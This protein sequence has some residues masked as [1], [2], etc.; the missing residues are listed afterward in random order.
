MRP[1]LRF[2][3]WATI[4]VGAAIVPPVAAQSPEELFNKGNLAYEEGRFND[5]A[6]A[7]RGLLRYQIQ[8]PTLEYNLGNAEFRL[9]HLGAA[10]L[11][12]ERARRLEPT[13]PDIRANL[14]YAQSFRFDRVETPE[15]A[16]VV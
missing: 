1:G 5:A 16:A 11:H 4:V 13:D 12:Y 9:G 14:E 10:I 6:M 2:G 3:L 8:D 7:Y 15:Q